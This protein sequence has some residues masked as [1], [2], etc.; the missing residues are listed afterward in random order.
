MVLKSYDVTFGF[1]DIIVIMST[2]NAH[3]GGGVS[4][5]DREYIDREDH[6]FDQIA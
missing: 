2:A 6:P 1:M 3:I 4:C 5:F